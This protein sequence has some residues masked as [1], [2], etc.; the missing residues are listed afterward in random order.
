VSA[1]PPSGVRTA[2]VAPL[3][4]ELA[5]VRAETALERT[6]GGLA[7]GRFGGAPVVLAATG[8][9]ARSAARGLAA[10]LDAVPVGRL[11]VLG[12]AGGLSPDLATGDLVA[13]R[14][15]VEDG[16]EVAAAD[17]A[18]LAAAV[19]GGAIPGT[20]LST[21]RILV[22]PEEKRA[23]WRGLGGSPL[24]P[25]T[26]D[27]ESAAYARVAAGRGIPLLVVRAVIDAAGE[28][29][30][31]D[32]NRCR[33]GEGGVDGA[34]VVGRALLRPRVWGALADLR[35]RL[36]RS[37]L[38]LARLAVQLAAEAADVEDGTARSGHAAGGAR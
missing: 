26:V 27:L 10:V 30:P 17:P 28:T 11:L 32:F 14:R 35:R 34:R 23:A 31:L 20:A 33:A 5:A 24:G 6:V 18:W 38:G 1:R 21:G 25:A 36:R 15:V 8:D 2:I 7:F 29:L 12:V 9:G 22:T 16:R 13:A 3:A 4:A 19:A 37:A